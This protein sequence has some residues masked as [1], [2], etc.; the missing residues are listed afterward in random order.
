SEQLALSVFTRTLRLQ[1]KLL[2]KLQ[3]YS[4]SV[5][6]QPKQE[7][8]VQKSSSFVCMFLQ[9]DSTCSAS[10]PTGQWRW[11]G[12]RDR[13]TPSCSTSSSTSSSSLSAVSALAGTEESGAYL[14]QYPR[15]TLVFE[16]L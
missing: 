11:Y 13:K 2:A 5:D 12:D 6:V 14:S 8:R 16:N 15:D 3:L 7:V 9:V 10:R 4:T 1:E